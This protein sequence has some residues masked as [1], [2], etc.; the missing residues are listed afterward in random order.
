MVLK[1]VR[2]DES[3]VNILF[4]STNR[5][6]CGV[7]DYAECFRVALAARGHRVDYFDSFGVLKRLGAAD[8]G[9]AMERLAGILP[10]YDVVHLQHEF[11]F[12]EEGQAA[13]FGAVLRRFS[14]RGGGVVVTMH[15]T[16][17]R[18]WHWRVVERLFPN[19]WR[20]RS[21]RHLEAALAPFAGLGVHVAHSAASRD[22]L[23]KFFGYQKADIRVLP[24]PVDADLGPAAGG[25]RIE[26]VRRELNLQPGDIVLAAPGFVSRFKGQARVVEAMAGLPAHFKLVVA[27]GLHPG[28]KRPADLAEV[29]ALIESLRLQNRV[30]VTGY[31]EDRDL[32]AL[33]GL[34]D[35]TVLAYDPS[36]PSSSGV[37][38]AGLAL[39]KCA[40]V[41]RTAPFLE[42]AAEAKGLVFARSQRPSDLIRAILSAANRPPAR[43]E[44]IMKSVRKLSYAEIAARLEMEV[45]LPLLGR[46]GGA[47]V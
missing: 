29:A 28:S 11:A 9:A 13:S 41:T 7:A 36:Y 39:G 47:S 26:Q 42:L 5:E 1:T 35:L 15:T 20:A 2:A 44:E 4:L 22:N 19:N 16:P 45:Y 34:A 3:R 10:R 17:R 23:R 33:I 32:K 31:L 38:A 6:P 46:G 8:Y 18:P 43:P 27:G 21:A 12:F 40:V 37:L 14:D 30:C 25:P 24:H